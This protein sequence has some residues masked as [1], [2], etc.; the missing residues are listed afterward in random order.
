MSRTLSRIMTRILTQILTR[1]C[2][3][4]SDRARTAGARALVPMRSPQTSTPAKP[5]PACRTVGVCVCVCVC[6]CVIERYREI[7]RQIERENKKS[8]S[9]VGK[10]GAGAA[11]TAEMAGGGV[12]ACVRACVHACACVGGGGFDAV[13]QCAPLPEPPPTPFLVLLLRLRRWKSPLPPPP[14]TPAS[15][16]S[17]KRRSYCVG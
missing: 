9:S 12:R 3:H 1:I 10:E 14:H 5:W 16:P 6:V 4:D 15:F 11:E 2:Q 17:A 7:D 13:K 8:Q